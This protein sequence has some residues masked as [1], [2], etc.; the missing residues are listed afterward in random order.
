MNINKIMKEFDDEFEWIDV[1]EHRYIDI[2]SFISEKL[3]EQ[4]QRIAG[5]LEKLLSEDRKPIAQFEIED[6]IKTLR[7][8]ED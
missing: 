1:P 2:K 3:T 4:R 6:L 5:E 7:E 8:G